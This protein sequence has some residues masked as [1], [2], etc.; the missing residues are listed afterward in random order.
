MNRLNE[1]RANIYGMIGLIESENVMEYINIIV[2]DIVTDACNEQKASEA[3]FYRS[4]T[5]SILGGLTDTKKLEY[6]YHFVRAKVRC[7]EG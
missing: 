1:L 6:F 3:A 7:N 4:R 2:S 5:A